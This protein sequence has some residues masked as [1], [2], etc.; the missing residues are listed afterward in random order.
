MDEKKGLCFRCEH[1]ARFMET[2]SGPRCECQ[3]REKAVYSCYM[4]MPVKPIITKRNDGDK[5][6][7]FSGYALSARSH[8][9]RVAEG[10]LA[11]KRYKDGNALY[12][13]LKVIS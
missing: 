8:Y 1:R 11:M 4:Y 9:V 12:W 6:P 2:G 7:Q 5:R 13:E 3:D 10:K